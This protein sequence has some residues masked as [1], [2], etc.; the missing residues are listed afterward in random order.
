MVDDLCEHG[1]Q[2]FHAVRWNFG[3]EISCCS[4]LSHLRY[5]QGIISIFYIVLSDTH[6][7]F[8][9]LHNA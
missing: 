4:K 8:T 2:R 5:H 9:R 1:S 3:V 7:A 6:V